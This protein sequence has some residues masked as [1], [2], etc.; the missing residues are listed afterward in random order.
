M[1]LCEGPTHWLPQNPL[2]FIINILL[3]ITPAPIH[4]HARPKYEGR[5]GGGGRAGR[6][7]GREG[8]VEE[9]E[10]VLEK[11]GAK[12]MW[13]AQKRTMNRFGGG[14]VGPVTCGNH[15]PHLHFI[16]FLIF[17]T[18]HTCSAPLFIFL[19]KCSNFY[20]LWENR[21]GGCKGRPMAATG[22]AA[23]QRE[24]EDQ[25]TCV[26]LYGSDLFSILFSLVIFRKCGARKHEERETERPPLTRDPSACGLTC[27]LA[28]HTD[29]CQ[30]ING[31]R[32]C[33]G[34][35]AAGEERQG[36]TL[37]ASVASVK[38][39]EETREPSSCAHACEAAFT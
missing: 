28:Y 17:I 2:S 23:A 7:G 19:L 27:L 39:C 14:G 1:S 26:H 31:R 18:S 24:A 20:G 22:I 21:G 13:D 32:G 12:G 10:R 38:R 34:G 33:G 25:T 36:G 29:Q 4:N 35:E 3:L 6:V 37:R 11:R 30:L 5:G 8:G 9:K 15:P 16:L